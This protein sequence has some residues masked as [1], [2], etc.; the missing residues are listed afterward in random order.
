ML[1]FSLIPCPKTPTDDREKTERRATELFYKILT[2][3][4]KG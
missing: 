2:K 3:P 4:E 1:F